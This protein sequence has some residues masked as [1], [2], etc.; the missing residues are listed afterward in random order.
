MRPSAALYPSRPTNHSSDP[1]SKV[2]RSQGMFVVLGP[3][4]EG[5]GEAPND[6]WGG[7]GVAQL[8]GFSLGRCALVHQPLLAQSP[9]PRND[10]LFARIELVFT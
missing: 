1:R 7:V 10:C 2:S 8:Q 5:G 3:H 4:P 9:A 6:K